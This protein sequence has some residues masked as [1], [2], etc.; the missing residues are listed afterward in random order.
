MGEARSNELEV[1][2]GVR[3]QWAL[4]IL[5]NMEEAVWATD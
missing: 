2:G 4:N 3:S 5:G 1:E